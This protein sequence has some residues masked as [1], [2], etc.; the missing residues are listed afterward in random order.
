MCVVV[1]KPKNVDMPDKKTLKSC[2]ADNPDGAGYVRNNGQAN[3]MTKGFMDF[4]G[5]YNSIMDNYQKSD[6][7]IIHFR[8]CS[9]GKIS[10]HMTHPFVLDSKIGNVL[11]YTGKSLVMAHNGH[12]NALNDKKST[13]SDTA[14]LALALG[15]YCRVLSPEL[16]TILNAIDGG[17][18]IVMDAKGDIISTGQWQEQ[19]GCYFSNLNFQWD[20]IPFGGWD[21]YIDEETPFCEFCMSDLQELSDS[22]FM[23]PDCLTYYTIVDGMIGRIGDTCLDCGSPLDFF[24]DVNQWVCLTKDCPSFMIAR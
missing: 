19:D 7:Y 22:V 8:W 11:E 18:F 13:D 20:T 24:P 1:Y 23:C 5:L 4:D 16:E 10:Q 6:S 2:W 12:I 21:K 3:T 15:K 14:K 17:K 9:S